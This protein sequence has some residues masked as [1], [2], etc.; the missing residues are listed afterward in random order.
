[1]EL[2]N[3]YRSLARRA[4]RAFNQVAQDHADCVTCAVGCT[5][6]CHA[7][8]GLFLVEAVH[9]KHHFD[10]L[11]RKVRRQVSARAAKAEKELTKLE[12]KMKGSGGRSGS[13]AGAVG[14]ERVRCPL[15]QDNGKCVLYAYRPITCRVYG[16]PTISRGSIHVCYQTGFKKGKSY[17]AFNLDHVFKELH[18]LSRRLLGLSGQRNMERAS[19]LLSIPKIIQTSITGLV[20]EDADP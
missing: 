4:D 14:M 11:D 2:F 10:Q 18:L 16:I 1:M 19:F 12:Q 6:C 17:P 15:L 9:L 5:D 3:D 7:V 8:F 13:L 20:Q